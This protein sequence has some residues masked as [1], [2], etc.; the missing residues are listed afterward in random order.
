MT[1][2]CDFYF[3]IPAGACSLWGAAQYEPVLIF[4]CLPFLVSRP[5]F[6][7]RQR[8]LKDF[9]RTMLKAGLWEGSGKPGGQILRQLLVRS[10]ALCAV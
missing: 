1:R 2:E 3:K 7:V 8:L 10:R 5:N 6:E 4:V 9:H